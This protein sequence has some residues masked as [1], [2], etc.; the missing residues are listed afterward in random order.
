MNIVALKKATG[1][2]SAIL[3]EMAD[4]V[5]AG[6]VTDMVIASVHDGNY[7]FTYAASFA[8]CVV[9]SSL[10]HTNCIERMRV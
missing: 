4:Q 9:M 8:D 6:T 10:L 5:D 1:D 7:E 3:R 2:L